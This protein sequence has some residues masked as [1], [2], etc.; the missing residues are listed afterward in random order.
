MAAAAHM[1]LLIVRLLYTEAA[2]RTSSRPLHPLNA[3]PQLEIYADDVKCTHGAT[4]GQ[5]NEDAGP[6]LGDAVLITLAAVPLAVAPVRLV[7]T[8]LAGCSVDI[9]VVV[10]GVGVQG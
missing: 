2:Q 8:P 1:I 3:Q 10:P 9:P 4:I 7:R 5:V 6:S